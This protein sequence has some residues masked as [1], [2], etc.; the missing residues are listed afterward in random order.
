MRHW[1]VCL[2]LL[3]VQRLKTMLHKCGVTYKAQVT[4]K[5]SGETL[6]LILSTNNSSFG[7]STSV[8][9][10]RGTDR[11]ASS[12]PGSL[13]LLSF[14]P[15]AAAFCPLLLACC[16]WLWF[17]S[18]ASASCPSALLVYLLAVAFCSCPS[19]CLSCI[20]CRPLLSSATVLVSL[21]CHRIKHQA[22]C[23]NMC[24]KHWH[25]K[26]VCI[27]EHRCFK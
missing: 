16:L 7:R 26:L 12:Y 8:G 10:N 22:H 15:L 3:V 11:V 13:P 14:H 19:C 21:V 9:W 4:L 27:C 17:V 25:I 2:L 18:F 1:L 5:D 23:A 20:S 6:L 24:S